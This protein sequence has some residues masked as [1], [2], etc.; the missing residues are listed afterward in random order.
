MKRV[1]K[2]WIAAAGA[3]VLA[4]AGAGAVMAQTPAPGTS[5]TGTSF[6]S[7]VAQKLGIDTPTLENA[8]KSAKT[9]E[10]DARVASGDLTQAQAD[11]LKQRIANAPAGAPFFGGGF[12]ERG[13]HMGRGGIGEPQALADFLGVTPETLRTERSADGA[14]LATVA[15]AHGKSRDELKAFLTDQAKTHLAQEV[16]EGDITQAQADA[17]LSDMT[18]NLD[19]RIDSTMPAFGGRGHDGRGPMG[20]RG[21][22]G[23]FGA[24][25]IP[26]ATG[27][28]TANAG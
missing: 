18:A 4:I 5:T 13:G 21:F 26:D 8:V 22:G 6:L 25:S 16:T 17:R 23:G 20:G 27:T 7:R 28:A 19:A 14:T 3:A 15:Q 9:D 12:G 1:S 10:I 11:A 24:P 2:W